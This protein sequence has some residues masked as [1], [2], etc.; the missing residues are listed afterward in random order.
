MNENAKRFLEALQADKELEAA[1]KQALEGIKPEEQN[2]AI[3][4][5]AQERGFDLCEAD[6]N[7]DGQ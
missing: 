5:F 4:K 7:P 6:L 3:V 1:F 2:V